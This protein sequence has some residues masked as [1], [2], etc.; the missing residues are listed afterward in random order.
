MRS[1][2][3]WIALGLVASFSTAAQADLI[4]DEEAQCESKKEGD[5]CEVGDEQGACAKSTCARNDYS[6]GVPPKTKQVDCMV[7]ELGKAPELAAELDPKGDAS[8][9]SKDAT[10]NADDKGGGPAAKKAKANGCAVGGSAPPIGLMV[11]ALACV[12]RRVRAAS[13]R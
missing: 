1:L 8:E 7:C 13:P 2:S 6:E 9:K 4:S 12:R 11:L 10:P 3:A 5:A